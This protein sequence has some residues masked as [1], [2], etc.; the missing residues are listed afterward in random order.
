MSVGPG[1]EHVIRILESAVVNA[2]GDPLQS[3]DSLLLFPSLKAFG[4]PIVVK[5]D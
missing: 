3:A 1:S 4:V 5:G 2:K